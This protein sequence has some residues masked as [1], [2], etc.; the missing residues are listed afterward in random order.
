MNDAI[1]I[2][3]FVGSLNKR[4]KT[5]LK[6][7]P[8]HQGATVVTLTPLTVLMAGATSPAP[9]HALSSWDDRK[10]GQKVLVTMVRNELYVHGTT[11]PPVGPGTEGEQGIPGT[12][13]APGAPGSGGSGGGNPFNDIE[14]LLQN[15]GTSIPDYPTGPP[16]SLTLAY[17][18]PLDVGDYAIYGLNHD[19]SGNVIA[20]FPIATSPDGITWT[21]GSSPVGQTLLWSRVEP[22]FPTTRPL[23]EAKMYFPA[24]PGGNSVP[25][26]TITLPP[27]TV[28]ASQD[29][30]QAVDVTLGDS[31]FP[32][33][34]GVADIATA[35]LTVRN[36]DATELIEITTTLTVSVGSFGSMDF[37]TA[38][39]TD[40]V[41]SDL[42]W[43]NPNVISAAGG[44]YSATLRV[45]VSH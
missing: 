4:I 36:A 42:S 44:T 12:P 19:G 20:N 43:S 45:A 21:V 39:V 33:N 24:D 35:I 17:L 40:I 3:H 25:V 34:S 10:V 7:Q 38:S 2:Q 28:T 11:T 23:G 37:S 26:Q 15:N 30:C 18:G 14:L 22:I 32:T 8:D 1:L 16:D 5:A 13:G 9:A 31:N 41:G 29:V 6:G 27:M